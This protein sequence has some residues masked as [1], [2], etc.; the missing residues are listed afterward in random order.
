MNCS[1]NYHYVLISKL[2]QKNISVI[3]LPLHTNRHEYYFMTLTDKKIRIVIAD[4]HHI[5][6]DGLAALL[7]AQDDIEVAGTYNEGQHLLDGLADTRPDIALVDVSMPQISGP[8]LTALIR[9]SHPSI[10][11]ITLS[12]HDDTTYIRAMLEAGAAGYVLKTANN[13]QLLDAIRA[14]YVG[15]PYF[16]PEIS[17]KITSLLRDQQEGAHAQKAPRLTDREIEIL[18]LIAS[19]YNNGQ[20][21][22][23]LFISERTVE[24]HRKNM[25]R[26][27][28][29]KTIVGLVKYAMEHHLI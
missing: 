15:K 29:N 10:A 1:G 27:T 23:R 4:D 16:S 13:R 3:Y 6:L 25:M 2:Q 9:K 24:T 22:S 8:E 19:E 12:M 14:V 21:A 28:N 26:K 17:G 20:I 7:R 18:R 5:M 11:V